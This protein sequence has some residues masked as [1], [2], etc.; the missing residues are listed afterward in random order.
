MSSQE[1]KKIG[2]KRIVFVFPYAHNVY[3]TPILRSFVVAHI[4]RVSIV[5]YLH[6]GETSYVGFQN[7][8]EYMHTKYTQNEF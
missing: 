1:R 7:R 2:P 5:I 6:D 3:F 8:L 4:K